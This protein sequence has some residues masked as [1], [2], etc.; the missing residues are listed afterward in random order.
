[1]G[2]VLAFVRANALV[3]V[4]VILLSAGALW[5]KDGLRHGSGQNS[6]SAFDLGGA[7]TL[8]AS[9]GSVV[10]E[11]SWPGK[12]LLMSFGYRFCPD[13]CPTN[14]QIISSALDKLGPDADR[15]QPLFVSIDPER[16]TPEGMA[17]YVAQFHPRL[18]GLT[19][20][21]EQIATAART[22]RVYYRKVPGTSGDGYS[23]D[24]SAFTYVANDRGIVGKVFSHDTPPEEMAVGLKRLLGGPK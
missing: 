5:I 16:D 6:A 13:V 19:G 20:T 1:M 10:T 2:K 3:V 9:D 24:H 23:L 14:L 11:H 18:I 8:V 15:V 17:T 22:F 7:F 21:P 12:L 4:A